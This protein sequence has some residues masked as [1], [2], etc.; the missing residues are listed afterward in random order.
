MSFER[1][2]FTT[3]VWLTLDLC[4]QLATPTGS[5]WCIWPLARWL[6]GKVGPSCEDP[7]QSNGHQEAAG[8]TDGTLVMIEMMENGEG[9]T[10]GR[11]EDERNNI[12]NRGKRWMCGC[13][14]R[15]LIRHSNLTP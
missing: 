5:V 9:D 13:E 8:R 6:W 2:A 11:D 14:V 7:G 3:L 4:C 12:S 15:G 1:P 10:N